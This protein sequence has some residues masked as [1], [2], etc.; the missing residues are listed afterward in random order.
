MI[1]LGHRFCEYH[2]FVFAALYGAGAGEFVCDE[3]QK[4]FRRHA[5]RKQ[6]TEEVAHKIGHV[7]WCQ[8]IRFEDRMIHD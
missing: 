5:T 8:A 7:Q 6:V 4:L 3:R 2:F 1:Y